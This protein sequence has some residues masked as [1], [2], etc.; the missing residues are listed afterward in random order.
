MSKRVKKY[1]PETHPDLLEEWDY[2][3]NG[4]LRPEDVTFGVG[5]KVWWLCG[6]KKCGHSWEAA[7]Y[8]RSSGNRGCPACA[9]RVVTDKNRLSCLYPSLLIE[10]D[11]TKNCSIDDI[12]YGSGKKVAWICR[13]CRYKWKAKVRDRT[14]KR[15]GCPACS[16]RSVSDKNRFSLLFPKE[17]KEWDYVKNRPLIPED[18]SYASNKKV[19]W[20]C[21]KCG[22][23][24]ETCVFNRTKGHGC[25]SCA[26]QVVKD[27]NR[28]SKLFPHLLDEWD[29]DKNKVNP[30]D[31]CYSTHRKV[32]WL[33]K[34]C[35]HSW[36]VDTSRRTVS[37]CG[38]PACAGKVVTDK[39]RLSVL[40]PYLVKEWDYAKN[41]DLWPEDVSRGSG[42]K[43]WWLCGKGHSWK[44]VISSRTFA[45]RGC[46]RC[47]GGGISKISQKWLDSLNTSTLEREHYI[48]DLKIRVDGFDPA[49]NTVYEFLGD[50]WHG[51]PEVY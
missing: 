23:K 29:Y 2:S 32:W 42:K 6:K 12:S 7:V 36:R 24:W 17:A 51:N 49:T 27:T 41:G 50:Y 35:G 25:P 5:K 43:V 15:R 48:K 34:V 33:C 26:G 19:K 47:L 22:Y 14:L 31:L 8:S 39:N 21:K 20:V 3:K 37:G 45:S 28:F 44:A 30:E 10:W 11:I 16:G 1:L 38:C 9:G 46:S 18:V 4:N 13:V 40:Y